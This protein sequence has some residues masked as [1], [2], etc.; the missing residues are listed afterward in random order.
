MQGSKKMREQY[1]TDYNLRYVTSIL[2]FRMKA[3]LYIHKRCAP[4]AKFK[5][6]HI[7][8]TCKGAKKKT[9]LSL[10]RS[11]HYRG[12]I[13]QKLIELDSDMYLVSQLQAILHIYQLLPSHTDQACVITIE[14]NSSRLY[15]NLHCKRY[16][17]LCKLPTR[18]RYWLCTLPCK[19]C[20]GVYMYILNHRLFM[21]NGQYN[22]F[23]GI[24]RCS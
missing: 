8:I 23:L 21:L 22:F 18:K 5:K 15:Y 24:R 3:F 20:C 11:P 13:K 6:K 17:L 10:Y 2:F 9:N 4:I 14:Y 16:E 19:R 7:H 1:Y 12:K